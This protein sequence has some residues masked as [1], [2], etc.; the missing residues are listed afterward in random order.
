MMKSPLIVTGM[1]CLLSISHFEQPAVKQSRF[2]GK[3]DPHRSHKTNTQ[4]KSDTP[5]LATVHITFN[6]LRQDRANTIMEYS[7]RAMCQLLL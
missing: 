3:G 2:K 5:R 1:I 4:T 7:R 6:Q